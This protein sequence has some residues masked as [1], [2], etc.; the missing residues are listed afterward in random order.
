MATTLQRI[1]KKVTYELS[2]PTCYAATPVRVVKRFT[3]R[4]ND[5]TVLRV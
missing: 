2:G 5:V 3:V 1:S 4:K